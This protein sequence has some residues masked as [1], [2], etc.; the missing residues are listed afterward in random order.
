MRA[1]FILLC[2][3]VTASICAAQTNC[4]IKNAYAF[5]TVSVPGAQMSDDNGNPI[6]PKVDIVRFIYIELGGTAKPQIKTVL[7]NNKTLSATLTAV[8]GRTVVPGSE[9]SENN[10]FK[11][12]CKKGN[13][14]WKIELQP[15]GDNSMPEQGCKNII[16]KNK[17]CSF[18]L[19]KEIQL[20]T[21]PRY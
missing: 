5:Y 13:S 3:L 20:A 7:Y 6:P 17:T 1:L 4:N 11:I 8:K 18:K 16:I 19:I 12:T 2:L 21:L 15:Q 14:L 10:N 9:L